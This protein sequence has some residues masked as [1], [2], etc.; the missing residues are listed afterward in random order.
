MIQIIAGCLLTLIG[1][2]M[3]A[4]VYV[5]MHESDGRVISPAVPFIGLIGALALLA[6]IALTLTWLG[7]AHARTYTDEFSASSTVPRPPT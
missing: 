2:G 7:A 4:L 6:G 1:L 3:I 5:K